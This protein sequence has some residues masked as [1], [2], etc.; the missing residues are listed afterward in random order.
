MFSTWMKAQAV[1]AI[2]EKVRL[3][4]VGE[5][6]ERPLRKPAGLDPAGKTDK[7]WRNPAIYRTN[8]LRMK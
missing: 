1:G 3:S 2:A 5:G 4:N 6:K 7:C 8:R